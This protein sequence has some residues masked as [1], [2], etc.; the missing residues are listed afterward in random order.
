LY[1]F[2]IDDLFNGINRTQSENRD[3]I[4]LWILTEYFNDK[5]SALSVELYVHICAVY[6]IP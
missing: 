5:K 4:E 2:I 3:E 1:V 6:L